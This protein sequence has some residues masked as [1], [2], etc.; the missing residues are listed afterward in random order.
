MKSIVFVLPLLLLT[1]SALFGMASYSPL[2][3]RTL[4]LEELWIFTYQRE[5]L[6]SF[7]CLLNQEGVRWFNKAN[8]TEIL[9]WIAN[10]FFVPLMSSWKPP[11]NVSAQ[12]KTPPRTSAALR[13]AAG[14]PGWRVC[15]RDHVHAPHPSSHINIPSPCQR[16]ARGD[17][18]CVTVALVGIAASGDTGAAVSERAAGRPK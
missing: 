6:F 5:S 9:Y 18:W 14:T 3:D 11:S 17:D 13:R 4:S 15:V 12:T 8:V 2:E 10:S 7:V 1:V 16:L